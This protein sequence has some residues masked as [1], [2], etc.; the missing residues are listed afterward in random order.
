VAVFGGAF[1]PITNSHL[2]CAAEI[3]HSSNA[4]EV[5][6]VPCGPRPDK[7]N[8]RTPAMDR[9]VMCQ[10]AVNTTFSQGFPVKVSSVECFA[11]EAFY[12]YDLLCSLRERHPDVDLAFLIGT[13]WLQPGSDISSWQSRNW[14]WK[15]GDPEEERT[16]VTGHKMLQE[17]DFIVM[18][19]PGFDVQPTPDDPTG[20]KQFGPR[21]SWLEMPAGATFIEG[22]LSSTEIR[23]RGTKTIREAVGKNK[24]MLIE[25]LVARAVL[26][27]IRRHGFYSLVEVAPSPKRVAVYGGAF[28]PITNSHLM[29]VA[30]IIHSGCADDVWL[31][32]C[33]P[34]PD[35]PKL[36]TPALDRYCMCKI[37][38]N[39]VFSHSFP[40]HV[41]DVECFAE[42]AFFTYDLLCELKARHPGTDFHFV[43]GSDWLQPQ[44]DMS[45]WTSRNWDWK[46]GDPEEQRTVVTGDR[47][48]AEFDFLV[49]PRPGYDVARSQEDPTG[50]KRFGPR[51]SWVVMPSDMTFMVGNLSSTEI[52]K[53]TAVDAKVRDMGLSAVD[54]LVPSGVLAYI[55]RQDLYLTA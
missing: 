53:R 16:V 31:V 9:Y 11:E 14:D 5:W 34:R 20:L 17:F 43:I 47:M 50:L 54:G 28:D 35:K 44:T 37:A 6:L 23:K 19:R 1:D 7:P 41:N 40:V 24:L 10:V 45:Q 4:D 3:V 55:C 22:N 52:R 18:K 36:K 38:V 39:Q 29:C 27:Y 48:L 46:P 26:S 42:E 21:L 15:P 2:T 32:P 33:G 12:T 8:L 49:I 13:D 25:G 30:N 51:L